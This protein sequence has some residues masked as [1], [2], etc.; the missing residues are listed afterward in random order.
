MG[1]NSTEVAYNFGQHGSMFIN[2]TA[3][4][5]TPPDGMVFIAIMAVNNQGATF[6]KLETPDNTNY[7]NSEAQAH[8]NQTSDESGNTVKRGNNGQTIS[9]SVNL[10]RGAM[11][12]GRWNLINVTAN[13][14]V[15][16]Y[17]GY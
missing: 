2:N 12:F 17:L 1:I 8:N 16:A 3:G 6:D 7:I 14:K 11:W 9:T 5:C 15:I 13:A 10:P 4:D